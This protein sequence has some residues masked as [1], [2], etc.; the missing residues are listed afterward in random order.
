MSVL[1]LIQLSVHIGLLLCWFIVFPSVFTLKFSACSL[2]FN[3]LFYTNHNILHE[4]C[5]KLDIRGG[6]RSQT[7]AL[8]TSCQHHMRVSHCY[9]LFKKNAKW[10][11]I[12]YKTVEILNLCC[13][14]MENALQIGDDKISNSS[15]V[16]ECTLAA[17][18]ALRR[19]L[20]TS[21]EGP[22]A[23]VPHP[24]SAQF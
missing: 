24:S 7:H 3:M 2:L 16:I 22:T 11:Y 10:Q 6:M 18:V 5:S 20:D 14:K 12:V 8:C 15:K 1:F 23:W 21:L 4:F 9:L 13:Q 19:S 17:E